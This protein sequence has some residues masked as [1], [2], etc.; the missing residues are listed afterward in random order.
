M[1]QSA[2]DRLRGSLDVAEAER[3]A[4]IAARQEAEASARAA[5]A[6]QEVSLQLPS[7]VASVVLLMHS[8]L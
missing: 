7:C 8:P 1:T 3:A 5:I 6:E 2:V 4:A